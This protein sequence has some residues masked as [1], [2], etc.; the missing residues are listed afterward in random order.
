[1]SMKI[2]RLK[3]AETNGSRARLRAGKGL[4]NT[5][6]MRF[7]VGLETENKFRPGTRPLGRK[8]Q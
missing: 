6:P 3:A 1:M 7:R 8:R 2:K 5:T 4:R